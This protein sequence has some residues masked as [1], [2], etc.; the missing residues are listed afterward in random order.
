MCR[1]SSEADVARSHHGVNDHADMA[2]KVKWAQQ[3]KDGLA[4]L[5]VAF[6][7][8]PQD[9]LPKCSPARHCVI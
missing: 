7:Q 3:P 5:V 4:T 1:M 2:A 8:Q 6:A 9:A